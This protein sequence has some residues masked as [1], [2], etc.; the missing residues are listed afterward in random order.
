MLVKEPIHRGL[1]HDM[2]NLLRVAENWSE[3]AMCDLLNLNL[4]SG[5]DLR[6]HNLKVILYNGISGSF[7]Q[8]SRFSR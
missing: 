5:E 2:K 7:K 3:I 6:G 4:I 1:S 8:L